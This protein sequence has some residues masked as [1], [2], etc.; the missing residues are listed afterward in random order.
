[1]IA[2]IA[3]AR[4]FFHGPPIGNRR[5]ERSY[6]FEKTSFAFKRIRELE[7]SGSKLTT[8]CSKGRMMMRA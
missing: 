3:K 1:L 7:R 4:S 6:G 2:L 5:P 8:G